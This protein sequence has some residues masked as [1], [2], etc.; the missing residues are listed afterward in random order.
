[1]TIFAPLLSAYRE[2]KTFLLNIMVLGCI[3]IFC[4]WLNGTYHEL[5]SDHQKALKN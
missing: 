4:G 3:G 2:N 1:M 5:N